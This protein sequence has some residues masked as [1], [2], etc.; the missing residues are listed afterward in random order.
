MKLTDKLPAN[1]ELRAIIIQLRKLK[2][3]QKLLA[4]L[5]KLETYSE[6]TNT[7]DN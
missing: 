5:F 7:N 2:R 1:P 4:E 6:T 3:N